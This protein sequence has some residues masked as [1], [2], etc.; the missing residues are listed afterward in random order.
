MPPFPFQNA[1]KCNLWGRM[2]ESMQSSNSVEHLGQRTSD[3]KQHFLKDNHVEDKSIL[4]DYML[5]TSLENCLLND[6][7]MEC[8]ESSVKGNVVPNHQEM[9]IDHSKT[10][11]GTAQ[12]ITE[13]FKSP[14]KSNIHKSLPQ[15][16]SPGLSNLP[17]Q[18]K[19]P[20]KALANTSMDSLVDAAELD[21]LLDG[22]EWSPM[23]SCPDNL[24]S[25]R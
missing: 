9:I 2:D 4:E 12:D 20:S 25:A 22:V 3:S 19:T 13:Q 5:D 10:T 8:L 1:I 18:T 11:I 7:L 17:V 14:I 21:N 23:I 24:H 6:E 15:S 16:T